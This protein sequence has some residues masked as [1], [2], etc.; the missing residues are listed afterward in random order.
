[1]NPDT[2]SPSS[3][4]CTQP[5]RLNDAT[6]VEVSNVDAKNVSVRFASASGTANVTFFWVVSDTAPTAADVISASQQF[7]VNDVLPSI[8]RGQQLFVVPRDSRGIVGEVFPVTVLDHV[9]P[10]IVNASFPQATNLNAT[11]VRL[12]VAIE[13]SE[14]DSATY[15]LPTSDPSSAVTES[16]VLA[17]GVEVVDGRVI[18]SVLRTAVLYCVAID[19]SDN[20]SPVVAR[21]PDDNVPPNITLSSAKVLDRAASGNSVVAF[22]F[23]ADELPV[24]VFWVTVPR[25]SPPPTVA[26]T[27]ASP[28]NVTAGQNISGIPYR[29]DVYAVPVDAKGNVGPLV[30]VPVQNRLPSVLRNVVVTEESDG[31]TATMSVRVTFTV[32]EN[33]T[34]VF[35]YSKSARVGAQ[36]VTLGDPI[37]SG[38][39]ISMPRADVLVLTTR[40]LDDNVSPETQY[41]VF[42][43]TPSSSTGS[44]GAGGAMLGAI[45]GAIAFFALIALVALVLVRRRRQKKQL[46]EGQHAGLDGA[47][48][49]APTAGALMASG[50]TTN[51]SLLTAMTATS[52]L[53]GVALAYGGTTATS[54]ATLVDLQHGFAMLDPGEVS[55]S[56][57]S[58]FDSEADGGAYATG[59]T[60]GGA[61]L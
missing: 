18:A 32:T 27:L 17:E 37:V 34:E 6:A 21:T 24:R 61:Y 46:E 55:Q 9:K 54:T 38:Q 43:K 51:G 3:S 59:T 29:T 16:R 19:A 10:E 26:F 41:A 53:S 40:D 4:F 33:G 52:G 22:D 50:P 58:T 1:V 7:G 8:R 30:R 25:G 36:S 39:V 28:H 47:S 15:C 2:G 20:R 35:W 45:A 13:V 31:T 11:H 12:D 48:D 60:G 5:P 14:E 49:M 44:A 57:Y 42:E 56:D 23:V